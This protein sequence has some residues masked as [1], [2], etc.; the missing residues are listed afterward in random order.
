M[1]KRL[2][3]RDK[4]LRDMQRIKSKIQT[5]ATK[6]AALDETEWSFLEA[7]E[8]EDILAIKTRL[9]AMLGRLQ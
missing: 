5:I 7:V 1:P 8:K 6:V 2:G 3:W 9:I 4:D